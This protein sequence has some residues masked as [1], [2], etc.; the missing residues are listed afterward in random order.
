MV[1]SIEK[2]D[3]VNCIR[4]VLSNLK[5]QKDMVDPHTYPRIIIQL[6]CRYFLGK[7]RKYNYEV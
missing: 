2:F 3:Y 4:K 1:L 7:I 6:Y 5:W